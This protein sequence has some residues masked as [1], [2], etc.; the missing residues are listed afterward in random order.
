MQFL[1][2]LFIMKIALWVIS[3]GSEAYL[4]YYQITSVFLRSNTE[5]YFNNKKKFICTNRLC[6]T[7]TIIS[8]NTSSQLY[9]HIIVEFIKIPSLHN[10]N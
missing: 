5:P 6:Q 10:D 1:D 8:S 4:F 2:N 3:L 7:L 9:T